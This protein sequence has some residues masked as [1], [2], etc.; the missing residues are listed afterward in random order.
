MRNITTALEANGGSL[1][2]RCK[3]LP[4]LILCL[5]VIS[6]TAIAAP[7][8]LDP[9][10]G[11]GGKVTSNP[12][13]ASSNRG[14][15]MAL[16]SDGK[17]VM[18]GGYDSTGPA[19]LVARYNADGSLDTTF[20]NNNGWVAVSFGG[21]NQIAVSVAIQSD[22]KIV[23]AG[24]AVAPNQDAAVARLNTDGS[25]DTSFSGD[26]KVTVD[27][28]DSQGSYPDYINVVKVASD[29]KI[30]FAGGSLGTGLSYKSIVGRLNPDGSLDTTF[31]GD[32]TL[33]DGGGLW[34]DLVIQADGSVVLVGKASGQFFSSLKAVKYS[35]F[36]VSDWSYGRSAGIGCF[37]G[38]NGIAAQPDGKFVL[39]GKYAC[40]LIAIRLNAN[41]TEDSTFSNTTITPNGEAYSVAVQ[42]DGKIVANIDFT[43]SGNGGFS[44]IRYNTNGSLDLGFGIGGIVSTSVGDPASL[45]AGKKVIIQ[46][47]EKIL[48][49]GAART[50][51]YRFAMVRYLGGASVP[52]KTLFDYDGDGKAD[53]SVFRPSEN[54]WFVLRT[55]DA[56]I[57]QPYF[58]TDGDI[59]TP[60]DFNGD[61]KTDIAIFR[62]SSGDWWYLD[63]ITG[64]FT[65][66]HW[67]SNGDIPLPSDVDGDGKADY[68]VYHPANNYWYRLTSGSEQFSERYFGT[69]GDK[70][71][72]GD[73]DG[74]G[75]SDPAIYRPSTG[76]FWYMSS[77]DSVHRPIQWGISTD[78]PVPADYDGDR[79]TDAAVYRPSTGTWYILNSSD[80]S[81][82]G[83]NFGLSDDKPVAA[84]YDGDGRADIA[85]F[86]PSTGMWYLQQTLGGFGSVPW[87]VATDIPTENSFVP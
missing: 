21:S 43:A 75:K 50:D 35:N 66:K 9:N 39:V 68:V 28:V 80:G 70:P 6:L 86:R 22:G 78:I 25:L 7:S 74:D 53:V 54:K 82:T 85:V 72:I 69:A 67:G 63:S 19:F 81:F 57:T 32:G 1:L 26:G 13:G 17:I 83:L 14:Y 2:Q 52:L 10:F 11:T 71:L 59:P 30:V 4:G 65:G 56:G 16:Q 23:V 31:A 40:K 62:P 3:Y 34:E 49:G 61:G 79:K 77:I 87:G 44:L 73:F 33:M 76:V 42:P 45:D 41:G 18:V 36:G 5:F 38:L 12:N 58:G 55:S 8:D 46:P 29:G 48:V 47:D 27:F 24:L 51:A 15:G 20:G 37:I 84:D 60:A 64:V